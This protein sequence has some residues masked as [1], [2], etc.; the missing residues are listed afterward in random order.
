MSVVLIEGDGRVY[1]FFGFI[2]FQLG[3]RRYSL[4]IVLIVVSVDAAVFTAV[5][6]GAIGAERNEISQRF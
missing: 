2:M 3:L 6:M 4:G 1:E 5:S